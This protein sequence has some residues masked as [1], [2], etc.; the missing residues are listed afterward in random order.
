LKIPNVLTLSRIVLAPVFIFF[1]LRAEPGGAVALAIAIAFEVTDLLDGQV[2]RLTNTVSDLGK[3][4]DPVADS[5]SRFTVFLC[6]LH[7]GYASIW[8]VAILF[9]RDTIV[10]A[11]RILGATKNVIIS[12]RWSGKVKAI[13]Q[14]TAII[15]ILCFTVW[16]DI[17]GLGKE[18]VAKMATISMWVVAG[19]TAVSLL[20]YLWGNRK[21]LA[22]LRDSA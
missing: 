16:P 11:L 20:D 3:F 15:S 4:M 12:A 5:L 13:F 21:I 10:A 2:A 14:G 6:F 18:N 19:V 9:Y 7:V 22:T 1:F 17:W 8:A